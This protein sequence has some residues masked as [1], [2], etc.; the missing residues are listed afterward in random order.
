MRFSLK[1]IT[2]GVSISLLL[3]VFYQTYWL[4]KQFRSQYEKLDTSITLAMQVADLNELSM[5]ISFVQQKNLEHTEGIRKEN[6]DGK[7]RYI[8]EN[9]NIDLSKIAGATYIEED[10]VLVVNPPDLLVRIKNEEG[11]ANMWNDVN[12][13]KSSVQWGFHSA[14][15]S[16][17]PIRLADYNRLLQLELEKLHI[18][19]PYAIEYVSLKNDSVIESIKPRDFSFA[20]AAVYPF[21]I[22]NDEAFAYHLYIESPRWHTLKAMTGPVTASLLMF[23]I[24]VSSYIILW[25]I[26]RQQKSIDEIKSDFTSNMTHELKTPIS[27]ASAAIEGLRSFGLG[28]DPEKR[29]EYLA[30]SQNQL[31]DLNHLV[32]QILTMSIENQKNLKVTAVDIPL[33]QLATGIE[34]DFKVHATKPVQFK[35]DIQPEDLVIQA[36]KTHFTNVIRNLFNNAIK[37]SK[38]K[39]TIRLTAIQKAEQV[40]LVIE[41][42]G[43]G[44]P[45]AALPK[46]FDKFYRVHSGNIH[47]VKGYGLGLHYVKTIIEKHGWKI[48][49]TSKEGEGTKFTINIR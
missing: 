47:D 26:I 34:A 3:V 21:I 23:A 17:K 20:K 14:L 29:E 41:D 15:D 11:E 10:S 39:V 1:L 30:I 4:Q 35:I 43:K 49:I 40:V 7:T 8:V 31:T 48:H 28:D 37:Y 46:V 25:R 2:I 6:K 19:I 12:M 24:L 13:L 22:D 9:K 42:N 38:E 36:D 32:E 18:Y 5:R 45:S 33:Y 16:V 44:I 27:I